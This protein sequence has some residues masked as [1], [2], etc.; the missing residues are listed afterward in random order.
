MTSTEVLTAAARRL[1]DALAGKELEESPPHAGHNALTKYR[2]IHAQHHSDTI[3]NMSGGE[4]RW[5]S[6]SWARTWRRPAG[7][8]AWRCGCCSGTPWRS[9]RSRPGDEEDANGLV[10]MCLR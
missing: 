1:A 6:Y 9:W 3:M 8:G 2:S 10:P 5:A 4:A 7:V